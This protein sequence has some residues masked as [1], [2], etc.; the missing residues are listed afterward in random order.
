MKLPRLFKALRPAILSLALAPA[1]AAAAAP[2]P[3]TKLLRFPDLAGDQVVFTYAGDLWTVSTAGG[4]ARRLT[5][6]P[7]VELF[8]KFSPDGQQIAFTGQ[9]EGDEQVYVI[10]AAGGEPRQLTYYPANGPLPP[11]WGYDNQVYEWTADGKS[12]LFR[13]LRDGY[14]LGDPKLF[15]VPAAG[16]LSAPLPMPFSGAGDLS[17][18]G[19][20]V[21][22]SP[23]FRDFRHWKRYEGGWAQNL[24]TFDLATNKSDKITS[25]VRT[26]RDPMWIGDK[27]YFAADWDG[28]LNLY[29]FDP[30]SRQTTQITHSRQWDVRWPSADKAGK[31]II[32]ELGGELHILALGSGQDSVLSVRVPTD[33]LARRPQRRSVEGNITGFEPGLQGKRVLFVAR[34]DLFTA[35]QEHGLTRNLTHSP[36]VFE[37]EATWSPDGATIAF[38][39]DQT[40]EEEI[41]TIDQEG[42]EAPRQLT[43]GSKTRYSDLSWSPD[44][45]FI[46][47]RDA[48]AR[49]LVLDVAAKKVTQVA[50]DIVKFGLSYSWSP[51]STW[52]AFSLGDP[53]GFRSLYLWNRPQNKVTRVTGEIFNEYQPSFDPKGDYLYYLADHMFQPLVSS[54]EF[55]FATDRETGIYGLALRKDVKNPFAPKSDEVAVKTA[56]KDEKEEDPAAKAKVG[57]EGKGGAAK[58]DGEQ[59]DERHQ[60]VKIELD[61][62][63]ERVF[64][65]PVDFDNIAY[66]AALED[67]LLWVRDTPF[68][69][70]RDAATQA[71][72]HV[73]SIS[74]EKDTTLTGDIQGLGL[75][76]DGSKILVRSNSGFQLFDTTAAGKDSPQKIATDGLKADWVPAEEWAE[77]FDDA[78]RR[79]RDFFYVANMHGYD[80][81]ALRAQ[82]RPLL[83]YV[84]HRSDLNYLISEMISEISSGHTYVAGGDF[85]IPKRPQG[86]LLGARFQLDAGSG[87]YQI[88]KIFAGQNDEDNYRSPLK[89]VGVEVAVGDYVLAINGRELKAP[90]QPE[91]FLRRAEG[92]QVELLVNGKP[93]TEGARKVTVK[94]IRNEDPLIYLEWVTAN[95]DYVTKKSNGRLGY[96]HIPDM[97]DDGIREFIKW[98]YGQT[99]KEGL[100]IDVRSNGGG[101]VS[102]MILNRLTRKLL[103]VDFERHS[104]ITEPYPGG[105]FPGHLAALIDED[106]ASD[107]DQFSYVF[108]AAGL[109]PLIGK[110]TWGGV[111]GIYGNSPLIDG[112]GVSIPEVGSGDPQGNWIIEGHGVDPDIEVDNDPGD[113]IQGKDAQLDKAI[114]Y[115]MDKIE[116]EPR[117]L[118]VRPA[119]PIKTRGSDNSLDPKG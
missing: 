71:E 34:G 45:K 74:G 19:K 60:P 43:S 44:S 7:G 103:M 77:I 117:K 100:V 73:Y 67:R 78:W 13:S 3:P 83:P 56:K 9:Y 113:L 101:N 32:Y 20:Q 92:D 62:L 115:L 14:D 59:P 114:E 90:D 76:A 2:L 81:E 58:K 36:G 54:V 72:L 52:I 105:V 118:P 30:G 17:P 39:S 51:C 98:Y 87:R 47:Y 33:A 6:H 68:Y 116:K 29:S 69:Y 5:T 111:V 15:L 49:L 86:A 75:A 26:E 31:R 10:D 64:R 80:W 12:V 23:L 99:T 94:P 104:E 50:D 41:W 106:T 97:G 8:G 112:G 38:V 85:N 65:V 55:D 63:A 4:D 16:G 119:A 82:Y 79:F 96:L 61:G 93:T 70:G 11:R 108:R 1:L 46:A 84:A 48:D 110:R 42:L 22:Y 102:Q 89:E 24:Y 28:K 57:K 66:L 37:R 27:I 88:A 53:N 18:D 25:N 40:G 35:P 21:V 91:A 95:R 109:G 107:G